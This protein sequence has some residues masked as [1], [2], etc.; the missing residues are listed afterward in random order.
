MGGQQ[1]L[2]L[3]DLRRGQATQYIGKIFLRVEATSPT[4]DQDRIDHHA[5]PSGLGMANKQPWSPPH[6]RRP[7][8]VLDQVVVDLEVPIAQIS[9]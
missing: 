4:A 7:D 5:A 3:G 2:D 8:D 9:S 1:F 6:G